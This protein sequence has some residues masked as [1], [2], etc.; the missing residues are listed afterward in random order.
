MTCI[1]FVLK[2]NLNDTPNDLLI[3]IVSK[4]EL[5]KFGYVYFYDL[6]YVF[7][8]IYQCILQYYTLSNKKY[9]GKYKVW[10][11]FFFL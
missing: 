6:K 7:I 11:V 4:L 5:L 9:A 2:I 10:Y 8:D 3:I 1:K